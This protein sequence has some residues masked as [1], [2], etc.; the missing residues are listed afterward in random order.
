VRTRQHLAIKD[1]VVGHR[2]HTGDGAADF[3]LNVFRVE[4]SI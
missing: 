2:A 1:G 3:H 4:T